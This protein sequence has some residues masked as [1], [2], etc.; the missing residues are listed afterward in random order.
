MGESMSINKFGVDSS[1]KTGL[2]ILR[3]YIVGGPK[4]FRIDDSGELLKSAVNRQPRLPPRGLVDLLSL[5]C[6]LV[7]SMLTFSNECL[8]VER[9]AVNILCVWPHVL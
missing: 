3:Q 2:R 5:R 4:K 8:S 7:V 9:V 6:L 1:G